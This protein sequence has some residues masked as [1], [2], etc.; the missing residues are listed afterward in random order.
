MLD[1]LGLS[2]FFS[3]N[4][5]KNGIGVLTFG[6]AQNWCKRDRSGAK[7]VEEGFDDLGKKLSS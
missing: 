2:A 6:F 1:A 3:Q 7:E 5:A 4:A